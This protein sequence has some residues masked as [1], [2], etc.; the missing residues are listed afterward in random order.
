VDRPGALRCAEVRGK[1]GGLRMPAAACRGRLWPPSCFRRKEPIW[2]LCPSCGA[3]LSSRVQMTLFNQSLIRVV[4]LAYAAGGLLALVLPVVA[5]IGLGTRFMAAHPV[6]GWALAASATLLPGICLIVLAYLFDRGRLW[7]YYAIAA[8]ALLQLPLLVVVVTLTLRPWA[9][10]LSLPHFYLIACCWLA[11]A[12]VRR[13]ARQKERDWAPP[14]TPP[15]SSM[16]VTVPPPVAR[17]Q[18]SER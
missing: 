3:R 6:G 16:G 5:R 4:R 7:A 11:W 13:Y 18:R 17:S 15:P 9:L 12:E 10:P 8:I 1:P 2:R 14:P